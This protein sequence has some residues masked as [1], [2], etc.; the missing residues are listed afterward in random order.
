[1]R[2]AASEQHF[3]L[4]ER[5]SGSKPLLAK[6]S[7]RHDRSILGWV[8]NRGLHVMLKIS[9]EQLGEEESSKVGQQNMDVSERWVDVSSFCFHSMPRPEC[10]DN[11]TRQLLPLFL[12]FLIC[13]PLGFP[14]FFGYYVHIVLQINPSPLGR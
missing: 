8:K 1:M 3:L 9:A 10:C 7:E 4:G 11:Q 12:Q 14:E 6:K 2:E 13:L 5:T